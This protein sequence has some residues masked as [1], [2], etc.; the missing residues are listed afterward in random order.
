MKPPR[1]PCR[2]ETA[3]LAA[4]RQGRL[5][6]ELL[7]H[8]RQCDLCAAAAHAG[9]AL[10]QAATAFASEA[11]LP[12]PQLLLHRAADERRRLATERALRPLRLARGSAIAAAAGAA[13]SLVPRLLPH[14]RWPDLAP[15]HS[16]IATG[17]PT[18]IA[19][20]AL[21]ITLLVGASWLHWQE[22]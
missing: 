9:A 6:D 18:W 22:T 5:N 4:A 10:R 11:R 12:D 17:W 16:L 14:L 15:L 3:V 2:H 13:V 19:M 21:L 20:G 8:M 1:L 7:A